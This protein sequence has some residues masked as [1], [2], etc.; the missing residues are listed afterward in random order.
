MHDD[1][2]CLKFTTKPRLHKLFL[3]LCHLCA[4]FTWVFF[5]SSLLWELVHDK[6]YKFALRKRGLVVKLA[7]VT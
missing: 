6:I 1:I 7:S 2:L 3:T 4:V 5:S